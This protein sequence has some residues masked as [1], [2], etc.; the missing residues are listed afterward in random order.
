MQRRGEDLRSFSYTLCCPFCSGYIEEFEVVDDHRAGKI[1]VQ[2][3][4]RLNKV[5]V[6]RETIMCSRLWERRKC[7]W[8]AAAMA[9]VMR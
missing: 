4:G 8:N 1:V 3:N 2:L 6:E 9:S 7:R 5:C